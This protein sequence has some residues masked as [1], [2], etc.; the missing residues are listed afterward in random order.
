MT[1]M[2]ALAVRWCAERP[3]RAARTV[4]VAVVM[5]GVGVLAPIATAGQSAAACDEL[6]IPSLGL[7]RC[8]VEGGQPQIDGGNVVRYSALS[9]TTVHW[10]A[11]HRTSHGSTFASLTSLRIGST[12]TYRGR[13]YIVT[14]YRRAN[15]FQPEDVAD[16]IYSTQNSL[17]LQTSAASPY[18]HVWRAV[19]LVIAAPM[20]ETAAPPIPGQAIPVP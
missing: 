19:E 15:R 11:G 2:S 9:S 6:S 7:S 14:D 13:L 3:T 20:V 5:L 12:V 18:V 16:W 4:L 10:L 1:R 17:A 8:V